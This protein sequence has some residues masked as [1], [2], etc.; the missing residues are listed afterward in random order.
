MSKTVFAYF[1]IVIASFCQLGQ[2]HSVIQKPEERIGVNEDRLN[3][4][5]SQGET[6]DH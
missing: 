4:I 6:I 3:D 5:R 2:R 1:G